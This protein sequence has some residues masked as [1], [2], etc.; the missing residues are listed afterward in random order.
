[1]DLGSSAYQMRLHRML[2]SDLYADH[3]HPEEGRRRRRRRKRESPLFQ[4]DT[5]ELSSDEGPPPEPAAGEPGR[6]VLSLTLPNLALA[7]D[8]ATQVA[9][10]WLKVLDAESEPPV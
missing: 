9:S 8:P 2:E 10:Y 6:P 7:G 3:H 5:L 1:V 4:E